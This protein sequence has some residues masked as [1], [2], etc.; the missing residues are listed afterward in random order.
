MRRLFMVLCLAVACNL[1]GAAG[2]KLSE[3]VIVANSDSPG[4]LKL[5]TEELQTYLNAITRK[6]IDIITPI[7]A[8]Q[9][10]DRLKIN[11]G[12]NSSL[13]NIPNLEKCEY[14][15]AWIKTLPGNNLLISGRSV[16][17]TEFGIYG[18]LEKYCGVRWF[19]PGKAGT[20]IPI[21]PELRIGK[22]DHLSNPVFLS[23]S[24][25]IP[26]LWSNYPCPEAEEMDRAWYRHNRMLKRF[27][28]S[29]NIGK[30]IVPSKYKKE[31]PEYYPMK[32][33]K[34][35]IPITDRPAG[36]Q[37]CMTNKDVIDICAQAAVKYFDENPDEISF[38]LGVNDWGNYCQCPECVKANGGEAKPNSRGLSDYSLLAFK[39]A[40]KVAAKLPPRHK[41]KYL[42]MLAYS[43]QRDFPEN[44]KF[45]P[46]VI[47]QR[48]TAFICYFNPAD[49]KD[50][51][52]TLKFAKN[53]NMF[54]VYE[55][56][57]G[58]GYLI[59]SFAIGLLEE[60]IDKLVAYNTRGWNSEIYPN[61]S[62]DG[63]K[64]YLLS[65]KL[66]N[67][68]LKI[69]VLLNDYCQKMFDAGADDMLKFYGI[70]RERWEGQRTT[71]TT[72]YHLRGSFKQVRIFD[73]KTC[74]RL[75]VL[76]N[77][78]LDK[79]KSTNGKI[80]IKHKINAIKFTR[81]NAL[82]VETA[83]EIAENIGSAKKLAPLCLDATKKL[84]NITEL[85]KKIRLDAFSLPRASLG[86]T[87]GLIYPETIAYPLYQA[88]LK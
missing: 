63:I 5:A 26:T 58:S 34:R 72:K 45:H 23:R 2:W 10:P 42:G 33:G 65:R 73:V 53:S 52:E 84:K 37:P 19:L 13:T 24:Y 68:Q 62:M 83:Q 74:N 17:G 4:N 8:K 1:C 78:A 38:S 66:W 32:K 70:C 57:Y 27:H 61:W 39:F 3:A 29:H 85:R 51:V 28:C 41:D 9:Y 69:Q 87:L 43:Y 50:M 88:C 55:Y 21:K 22:I 49:R 75:L 25:S 76:L 82:A 35:F 60:Y 6:K 11:I 44:F 54:S 86:R 81:D 71:E 36:W 77:S 16:K 20:Y 67:P 40:N 15:G 64:Y 56:W 14:D 59:P 31:H 7:Q 18:F 80:L 30:I 47:L 48:T 46:N 12:V 79:T